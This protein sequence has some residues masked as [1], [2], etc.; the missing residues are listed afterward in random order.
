MWLIK[1]D[2]AK[3]QV[4]L[5]RKVFED[6]RDYYVKKFKQDT[7]SVLFDR[8]FFNQIKPKIKK[9]LIDLV[10]NQN[11]QHFKCIFEDCSKDF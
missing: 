1:L 6:V 4:I 8:D 2:K 9:T 3:P 10:N 7:T 5:S 11:Y